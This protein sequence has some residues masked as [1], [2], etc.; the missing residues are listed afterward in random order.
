MDRWIEQRR[1]NCRADCGADRGG[2]EHVG[3]RC[4]EH[5]GFAAK[6]VTRLL[7]RLGTPV[8]I[9]THKSCTSEAE[10]RKISIAQVEDQDRGQV[11]FGGLGRS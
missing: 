2:A 11:I 5:V 8:L 6:R 10:S 3:A 9:E 1:A 4:R 7:L